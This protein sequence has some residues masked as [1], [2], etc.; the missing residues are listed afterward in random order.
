[1]PDNIDTLHQNPPAD[2]TDPPQKTGP[3]TSPAILFTIFTVATI[4][5]AN[6]AYLSWIHLSADRTCGV[7]DGCSVVLS[8]EWAT[9]A[10]IPVAGLGA[11]MY[12]ALAWFAFQVLRQRESLSVFEPWMLI[13]STAG[14]GFSLFLVALQAAVI[15]QW[16]PMC[17]L[18][19]G[20]TIFLFL[21]CLWGSSTSGSLGAALRDPRRL[22]RGLPQALLMLLLPPLFVLAAGGDDSSSSSTPQDSEGRIV[23]SIGAKNYTLADVDRAIR[24]ELH[25]LDEKR[26][27]ARIKFLDEKLVELEASHEKVSVEDLIQREVVE[28]LVVSEEEVTDY[29]RENRSRLPRTLSNGVIHQ[30]ENRVRIEKARAAQADYFRKLKVKYRVQYHLPLP[31]RLS[32]AINPRGG[33]LMGATDAPVTIIV[34]TDLRCPYCRKTHKKL[35]ALMQ[36]FPG[37]IQLAFRHYPLD[38]HPWARPAAEY[39]YCAQQQERFWP[40]VDRVFEHHG[41]LS[42]DILNTLAEEAGVTDQS[43]FNK[44]LQNDAARNA[45]AADI[46]EATGAGVQSTPTLFINGRFFAGFPD[47]IDT[48][49]R[50]E[51]DATR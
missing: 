31:Q 15:G 32:L 23:S 29:I 5:L 43:R 20:L 12:L 17:L 9:I 30:I 44:C 24:G 33:P 50:E 14:F 18:S 11:G 16:C 39:A 35:H 45:V 42:A 2:K 10:G 25:A 6:A 21:A 37:Q 47:N 41:Q 19:A 3:G 8:S 36:R 1:M 22:N 7:G 26:Y 28:G 13:L 4:G 40:F 51:L 34:F 38:M 49:I 27:R 46:A 48:I